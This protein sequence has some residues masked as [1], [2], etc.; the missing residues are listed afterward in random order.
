[1]GGFGLNFYPG[2]IEPRQLV[3][4]CTFYEFRDWKGH[5]GLLIFNDRI[6]YILTR[7]LLVQRGIVQG[8]YFFKGGNK[9]EESFVVKF[10]VFIQG[11]D[12]IF[13]TSLNVYNF[14]KQVPA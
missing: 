9:P 7:D 12:P 8:R 10:D 2:M 3:I 4:G 11:E 6:A 1:M 14:L 5:Q 13:Q